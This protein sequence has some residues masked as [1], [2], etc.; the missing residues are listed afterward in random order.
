MPGWAGLFFG[1]DVEFGVGFELGGKVTIASAKLGAE[2][3]LDT[4]LSAVLDCPAT[5]ANCSLTGSATATP[6]F[7]PQF[8]A[9]A[10]EQAQYEPT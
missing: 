1:G 2:V 5:S 4:A 6:A 8:T 3:K 10:L 9:P 7:E